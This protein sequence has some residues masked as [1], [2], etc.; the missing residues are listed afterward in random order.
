LTA[1]IALLDIETAPNLGYTWGKWDQ[2]VIAF[3][4]EW[5]MLSFAYK[6]LD[7]TSVYA[8]GLSD[9]PLYESEPTND[10]ELVKDLWS[11]YDAADIIV[12]HN[13]DAFDIKKSNAK[14]ALH[15][16]PPPATYKSVDTLKVARKH[17]KFESNKLDD[18][19]ATL[20]LGRKL[21]HSGIRLWF[22]C[23]EGDPKAWKELIEY[24]I[25]DVILL[26]G[27]YLKL[28]PWMANHPNLNLYGGD[29][30]SCPTCQSTNTEKRGFAHQK[31][32]V[33][34]R[35]HCKACGSWWQGKIVKQ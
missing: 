4:R 25:Q 28:R 19:G 5:Y 23:M 26:E 34:Q 3:Q 24:N 33:Y 8:R 22:R 9:Y 21:E 18:L 35:H 6:W 14:F 16:L 29:K 2:N 12:A 31:T 20:G 15:D 11:V 1:K 30:E 32:R 13:G 27:V 17:F 10:R 7:D